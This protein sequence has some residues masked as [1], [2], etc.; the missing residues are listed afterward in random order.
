MGIDFRFLLMITAKNPLPL[1]SHRDGFS[2]NTF[3]AF[4]LFFP[5]QGRAV[6]SLGWWQVPG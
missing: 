1:P 6:F 4:D 2:V 3:G 5:F